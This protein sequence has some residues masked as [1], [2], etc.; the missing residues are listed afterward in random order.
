MFAWTISIVF[1]VIIGATKQGTK[2]RVFIEG[3]FRESELSW[4]KWCHPQRLSEVIK[5]V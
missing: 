5:D 4:I 1:L 2:K 3:G